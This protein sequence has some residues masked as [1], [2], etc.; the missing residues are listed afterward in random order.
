[1][2][3]RD[4]GY[5]PVSDY[6]GQDQET[7]S[8]KESLGETVGNLGGSA[9][10]YAGE[11]G[12]AGKEM[13]KKY[14]PIAIIIIVLIIIVLGV[15]WV[16]GQKATLTYTIKALDGNAIDTA[17]I[18]IFY[19]DDPSRTPLPYN[20]EGASV[21][22]ITLDYGT[23]RLR[24]IED[25]GYQPY[26]ETLIIDSQSQ[27]KTIELVR[28]VDA[29]IKIDLPKTEI[30]SGETIEGIITIINNRDEMLTGEI[31]T[32]SSL[33]TVT[34]EKLFTTP[35]GERQIPFKIKGEK[36]ETET[37]GTATIWIRGTKISEK[38]ELTVY[39][40]LN[41]KKDVSI[42]GISDP[43][44]DLSLTAGKTTPSKKISI[45]NNNKKIPLENLKI[46][47]VPDPG[48]EQYLK[49]F[50]FS[51]TGSDKSTITIDKILPSGVAEEVTLTISVPIENEIGDEFKGIL[52]ME[53]LSMDTQLA[54]SMRF[55]V[56]DKGIAQI[57]FTPNSIKINCENG[58][59]PPRSNVEIGEIKN[60]GKQKIDSIKLTWADKPIGGIS[61]DPLCPLW[62]T[63]GIS[64]IP[65]LDISKSQ[66]IYANIQQ[67]TDFGIK[68]SI[69]CALK[70]EFVDPTNQSYTINQ[71]DI[72]LEISNKV[73]N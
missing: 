19:E 18:M 58:L 38:I 73:T 24:V 1:M 29:D 63:L 37:K 52:K 65:T 5:N 72:L 33:L 59:C 56:K 34:P 53:S 27:N 4:D 48:Y 71:K 43:F 70:W 31:M 6:Y 46:T 23:Y 45:N 17:K 32:K 51:N 41:V 16:L 30:F 50:E 2:Y 36:V 7:K 9:G 54:Y 21:H 67:T 68:T 40:T 14:L 60:S 11:A 62:V 15:M 8:F 55:V 69:L 25:N 3:D 61:V 44:T 49:W 12:S 35:R 47:I 13:V 64:E 42:K 66:A 20:K 22:N 39:P 26:T 28:D 57:T 10:Y